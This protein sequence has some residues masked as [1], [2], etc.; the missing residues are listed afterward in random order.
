MGEEDMETPSVISSIRQIYVIERETLSEAGR[1]ASQPSR[2]VVA[3]AVFAN[4]YA[5]Q[6]AASD[7]ALARLAEISVEIGT[8]LTQ[9]ALQRFAGEA[10]PRAYGKAALVGT[11][12]ESEHG[13]AL[14]HPRLGLAMRTGL[15]AGPALIPGNAKVGAA[16]ATIDLIFGGADNA[17]DYDAMDGIVVSVPGAPGPDEIAL[18]VGFGTARINARVRGASA[19][20][21]AKLVQDIQSRRT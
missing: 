9:K 16:G 10:R 17:W 12:G 8:V 13:A 6:G 21:V 4:P 5:G 11:N 2:H 18:F 14:I 15:G 19:E 3:A 7:E 20:Q 1:V